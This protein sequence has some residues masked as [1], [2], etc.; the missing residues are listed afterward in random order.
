VPT[1][2]A[3]NAGAQYVFDDFTRR[4]AV[5][6][7]YDFE[8]QGK[9]FFPGVHASYKFC[10]LSLVGKALR[11][12]QAKFAF[13][14][15]ST[16]E[17]EDPDRVFA[18]SPEEIALI[19][20]NTGT[21]PIF[22][23]RRD[24]DLTAAIYRRVPVLWDGVINDGNPW[25]ITFKHFFNMTDDSDLFRTHDQ[26]VTDGW[27]LN[28]NVFTRDG[29]RMLPL[30]EAKT[31]HL[32]DHRWN[33]FYGIGDDDRRHL[34]LIEK[35][36]PGFQAEPRYWIAEQGPMR[37]RRN[38]KDVEVPGVT[39]LLAELK[40][41]RGWLC[42]WRDVTNPTNERTAI[43]AFLPRV[44]VGNKF[45]L[46]FPS[47]SPVL[48]AAL[49]AAQSSLAFD[50]MSRRKIAGMAM[51]LFIWKQ[52]PVGTPA[53]FAPHVDFLTPRVVELVYTAYELAPL[54]RDLGDDGT[55]FVWDED[56]RA[57][58]RAE[59]DAFF[60]RLYGIERDE[61]DYVMETFPIVRSNDLARLGSYHTKEAILSFYDHMVTADIAGLP[62][63]TTITPRPG[64]GRRHPASGSINRGRSGMM[65]GEPAD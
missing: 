63:E 10:L 41:D 61:V 29:K 14:L 5:A 18:L 50:F 23:S 40:W 21:L 42:G 11:E 12:E 33:S 49:I 15:H 26:L 37:I 13:F 53:T 25:G 64:Y 16:A 9:R 17:L 51:G 59:L 35:N 62:Y 20:P 4:R 44:A 52:L 45:H 32:F 28:G 55:P 36:D 34:T 8:N 57:Q 30:Y 3:I 60:F 54:A 43:P 38:G 48:V 2:I 47:V 46:M 6:S 22:R 27:Q 39:E 65:N 31:V 56:R 24:A 19:D 1:T 58:I 7:L